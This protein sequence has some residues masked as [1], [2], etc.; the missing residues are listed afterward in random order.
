MDGSVVDNPTQHRFE[1]PVGDAIA[2]AY[3]RIEGDRVVLVHT[4]VPQE[5]SG[6]GI[7]SR[8]ASGVFELIRGSGRKAVTTCPF[9]ATWASRHPEVADLVVG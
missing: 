6:Q 4:E 9:M 2:A 7:G 1:L 3:Y 5:L 8:L